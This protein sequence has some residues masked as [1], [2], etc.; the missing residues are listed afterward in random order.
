MSDLGSAPHGKGN[1]R[2]GLGLRYGIVIP[3]LAWLSASVARGAVGDD[4]WDFQTLGEIFASPAIGDDGAVYFGSRDNTVYALNPDGS[5]KWKFVTGD[6]VDSAPTISADGDALY[7]GSWDNR[8]YALATDTGSKLWE[9]ETGNLIVASVAL[10]EAGNLFFGSS[11][12]FFYS[13]TSEGQLRWA[14]YIGAELDSSPAV[15][16]SGNVYV[17]GYDGVLYAF[18]GD[19]EPLWSY[20]TRSTENPIDQRIAGPVSIGDEGE[21][22]F[23]GGDG[24]VY[25]LDVD[26]SLLWDFDAYEKVDTGVVIGSDGELVF[27]SRSGFVYALDSFGVMLWDSFVGD[28]FFST[29]AVDNEGK[30]YVGSY[31]GNGIS[32]LTVLGPDG[33]VEWEYLL[34]DYIDSPPVIDS[35]GSVLFGGY[36]GSL[37]VIEADA[38]PAESQWYRFGADAMNTA[39]RSLHASGALTA[40]FEEWLDEIGLAGVVADPCFDEDGDGYELVLEYLMG[41][42]PELVDRRGIEIVESE[43]DGTRRLAVEYDWVIDEQ[44]LACLVEYSFDGVQWREIGSLEGSETVVI[45]SDAHGDGWYRRMRSYLPEEQGNGLLLRVRAACQ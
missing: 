43:L 15:D 45:D 16:G 7:V 6:W 20:E 31:L 22:F 33:D 35:S 5:L 13:L 30:I 14:Y 39:R 11:D 3:I 24:Y 28:V 29:P 36:D 18:S 44:L 42:N 27:A 10:D 12:G 1:R 19:G 34:L 17:G 8:L 32:G 25:A 41:G 26:G 4:I 21:I 9:F 23:G 40:R 38:S 37:H 2:V